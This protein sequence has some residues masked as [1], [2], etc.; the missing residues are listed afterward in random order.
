MVKHKTKY[1]DTSITTTRT[2]TLGCTF[3]NIYSSGVYVK[4]LPEIWPR[5][6]IFHCRGCTTYSDPKT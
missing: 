6:K 3:D 5:R 2:N 4:I 1:W